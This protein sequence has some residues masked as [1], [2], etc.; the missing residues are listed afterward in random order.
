L[1]ER[2]LKIIRRD[3]AIIPYKIGVVAV[4]M[5]DVHNGRILTVA[6]KETVVDV[7]DAADV[8]GFT[9]IA[10]APVTAGVK[11]AKISLQAAL[12]KNDVAKA[13]DE[14]KTALQAINPIRIT[15]TASPVLHPQQ[16]DDVPKRVTVSGALGG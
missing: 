9:E 8:W 14:T 11:A 6:D 15:L 5:I 12:G 4:R 2:F 7:R 3:Q 16:L 10:K 1:V 13:H